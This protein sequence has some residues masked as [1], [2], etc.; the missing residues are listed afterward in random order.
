MTVIISHYCLFQLYSQLVLLTLDETLDRFSI[1][2]GN[3]YFGRCP[4]L[5][6]SL[7][8]CVC[9]CV[10]VCLWVCVYFIKAP[11]HLWDDLPTLPVI[12]AN[13]SYSGYL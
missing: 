13:A 8:V 4:G 5:S 1:F 7:C 2:S 10:C 12:P 11:L 3:T 6:L 9:V